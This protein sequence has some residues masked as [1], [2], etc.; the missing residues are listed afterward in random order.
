MIFLI[1]FSLYFIFSTIVFF[2][3]FKKDGSSILEEFPFVSVIIAVRNEEKNVRD[4]LTSLKNQIFPENNFEVIVV[5]D[6]STDK[7]Q[8]I[9]NDEIKSLKH[10]YYT[11]LPDNVFRK[12]NALIHG[13]KMA[14]G[15]FIFQLDGDCVANK[16]WLAELCSHLENDYAI[17][18]G[19]TLIHFKRKLWDKLQALE[20]LYLHSICKTLS[21][22]TK[23]FSLFGNNTA[24]KKEA[25][26]R[27][28]GYE[29]I[30]NEILEDY[31]LVRI[32]QKE[33]A[34]KGQLICNKNSLVHTK[35]MNGYK[36]Y[37]RQRRLWASGILEVKIARK[38]IFF[39]SLIIYT[40]LTIYPF[41]SK[42][43]YVFFLLR[44]VADFLIVSNLIRIFRLFNLIPFFVFF[45][46]NS[47]LTTIMA[48]ISLALYPKTKWKGR[49]VE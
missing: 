34:N 46:I 48:G 47:I 45:H 31:Q 1:L 17:V 2:R 9:I 33:D 6:H 43:Y 25:Y 20:Y 29:G 8:Q 14:K 27:T 38:I 19:N 32:I 22:R 13:I 26:Y 3:T 41:F 12:R 49:T 30:H 40:I 36:D 11:N 39:V 44:L 42:Y 24:F 21:S 5:D 15:E 37:F 16:H 7:T 35:P 23:A 18:G 28:E 4:C 10:F